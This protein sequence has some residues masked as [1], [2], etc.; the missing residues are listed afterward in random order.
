MADAWGSLIGEILSPLPVFPATGWRWCSEKRERFEHG[1]IGSDRPVPFCGHYPF[2]PT[3]AAQDLLK[4]S[5]PGP[6]LAGN[7]F[8]GHANWETQK[9]Q[10]QG[11]H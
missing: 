5:C 9:I 1:L 3:S 8:A 4:Q 7:N 2:F 11:N 10:S 6:R